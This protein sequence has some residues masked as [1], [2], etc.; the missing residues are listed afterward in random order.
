MTIG[1]RLKR[2]TPFAVALG[3]W[4][5]PVPAG[6]TAPAWHLFAVF[7]AVPSPWSSLNTLSPCSSVQT[8]RPWKPVALSTSPI[9]SEWNPTPGRFGPASSIVPLR[10]TIE[11]TR[12]SPREMV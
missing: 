7:A 1:Q 9:T 2:A 8:L 4:F 3:I 6:L 11:P 10:S 12:S 5:F